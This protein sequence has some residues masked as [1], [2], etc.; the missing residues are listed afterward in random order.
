[1][2]DRDWERGEELHITPETGEAGGVAP[3][4]AMPMPLARIRWSAIW[5]GLLVATATQMVL[6]AFGLAIGLYGATAVAGA[7]G[8]EWSAVGLWNAIFAIVGLFVGGWT[9]ARLAAAPTA[10][11]GV[12]HGVIVW[13]LSITLG[14]VLVTVGILPTLGFVTARVLAFPAVQ[15]ADVVGTAWGFVIG[16]LLALAAAAGGGAL[17]KVRGRED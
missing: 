2:A 10:I 5:S 16:A 8:P 9:A 3:A 13:A 15:A 6:G 14:M 12:W 1:M 11:N 17:G 7:T 4:M